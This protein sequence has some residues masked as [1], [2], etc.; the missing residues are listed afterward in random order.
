[1]PKLLPDPPSPADVPPAAWVP[2]RAGVLAVIVNPAGEGPVRLEIETAVP[3]GMRPLVRAAGQVAAA[4]LAE[5]VRELLGDEGGRADGAD[6]ALARAYDRATAARRRELEG[7][8][9]AALARLCA[10][11]GAVLAE[12]VVAELALHAL[13][14]A[15][16][17]A[18]VLA[19]L[20]D[21]SP[22]QPG[23]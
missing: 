20:A 2:A 23:M 22:P 3:G 1:M 16:V 4:G 14:G 7:R 18:A 5:R 13:P 12:V 11:A 10:T 6:K 9:A 21:D 15:P 8:K 17:R 19:G